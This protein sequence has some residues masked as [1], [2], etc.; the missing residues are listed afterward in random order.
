[1]AW[2]Q[3]IDTALFRFVNHTL[4]N[5]VCDWLMPLLSGGNWFVLALFPFAA[6]VV[7]KWR[8][9]GAL[10]VLFAA[11]AVALGDG[12]VIN[13]LKHALDRPRPFLILA[14][15]HVLIG[16]GGSGSLPSAHAAN[17]F[18]AAMV[19]FIYFRRSWRFMFPF[20]TAVAFS[21]VYNGVHYPADVLVG[22]ILGAGYAAGGVWSANLL[23]QSFGKKWF[24]LW[25]RK[26][27]SLLV[28]EQQ[29]APLSAGSHLKSDDHWLR[30]G[31]VLIAVLFFARIAYLASGKI[32][33]SADEAYQWQ[34][35]KH[36]ALSYYSKPPL[37]AFTQ[38]FGTSVFGDTAFG[39]RWL[40]PV[41]AA[42]GSLLVLRFLAREASARA[43]FWIVLTLTATPM[44]AAGA[45]LMT[46]DALSVLFWTAAMLTGW[47]AIQQDSTRHWLWT[48]LWLG[49]GFL[50][51]YT[52][53][54]QLV[55]WAVFLLIWPT[56]R[57]QLR[58]PGPWLALLVIAVCSLPV[59]I[60]NAQHGWITLTHLESRAGL[61]AVWKPTANFLIDFT[62][63][64]LAL[65]NPIF[66]IALLWA[67]FATWKRRKEC[68]LALYLLCMGAPLFLG[69]WLYTLR[70]RVQPNW[71][72][73]AVLPLFAVMALH[74]ESRWRD[75]V[76]A[77][78]RWLAV[79]LGLGLTVV[80]VL[81]DTHLVTKLTGKNL[82]PDKDPLTRVRGWRAT[83]EVVAE[84]R[85]K[86]LAEGKPVFLIGSHYGVTSL[87]SFYLPEAKAGEPREPLAYYQSSEHPENQYFFWPGYRESRQGQNAIYIQEI[88]SNTKL[89]PPPTRLA[90]EFSTVA[91]LGK[92]EVLERGRVIRHIRL[93]ACRDLR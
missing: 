29:A 24:P 88:K 20:A 14:D 9:R 72:A 22:A 63:Q 56:A 83:A 30:L 1:M 34:W 13:T 26:L 31:Y 89:E 23:W 80:I 87:I 39:V 78:G 25:W 64:E 65:L 81:H 33:L 71:I 36:L 2:L 77:V 8:A 93:I 6:F 91:D 16:K 4:A 35:S 68:P 17:C 82:L 74:W 49:L 54:F 41:L 48:G 86:L 21:R 47:R 51:K 69:Y 50:A 28:P 59:L 67:G 84:Q 27:S 5:P 66:F 52:A 40:S 62:M 37:I 3:S 43:G 12:L 92:F 61:E 73:P 79:G 15:A 10:C 18:A 44:M 11:L 76:R 46:I 90:V 45:T 55:S 7:W 42:L 53:L 60:W 32:E 85:A 70:A 75:G 58:R 19:A 38:F 57:V